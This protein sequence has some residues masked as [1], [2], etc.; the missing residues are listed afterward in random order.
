MNEPKNNEKK[1]VLEF[2]ASLFKPTPAE[3]SILKKHE[4][5]QFNEIKPDFISEGR[6]SRVSLLEYESR[7]QKNRVIWKRMGAGK[8]LTREEA[9]RAKNEILPYQKS[10]RQFGWQMPQIYHLQTVTMEREHQIFSYE[11]PIGRGDGEKIIGDATEPNFRKWF[12]VRTVIE[13]MANYPKTSLRKRSFFGQELTFLPHGLD[14]KPANVVST[15]DRG[16]FFVDLFGPKLIDPDGDWQFYSKKL[17]SLPEEKLL[18]VCATKE[19]ALL[20]FLRLCELIWEKSGVPKELVR[21]GF[22]EIIRT[23][24]FGKESNFVINQIESNYPWLENLYSENQV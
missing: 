16:L 7:N 9:E 15:G 18:A 4:N 6:Q 20:R 23:T 13:Q 11:E 17:D 1:G 22:K 10:L 12:I 3:L 19:G 21:N 14:L 2:H 5:V 8:T 24:D